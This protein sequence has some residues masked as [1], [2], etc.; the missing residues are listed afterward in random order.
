MGE[1]ILRRR[2]LLIKFGFSSATL[3]RK[4]KALEF[5]PPLVLG[6]NMRGWFESTADSYLN[7]LKSDDVI[8]PVAP[9]AK[10]GRKPKDREANNE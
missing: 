5:P 4:I 1:K 9:G 8:K 2:A 6:P 7:S 10:R 3:Y